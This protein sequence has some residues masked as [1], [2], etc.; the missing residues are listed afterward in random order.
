MDLSAVPH[1]I[2]T[3]PQVASV[4]MTEKQ[5]EDNGIECICSTIPMELVP[6]SIVSK[7]T[8]GLVKMVI[9]WT[10]KAKYYT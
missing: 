4:G 6:K 10:N 5:A 3:I 8:R 7:D 2:F 9:A 1:A